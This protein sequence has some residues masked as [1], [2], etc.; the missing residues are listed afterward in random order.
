VFKGTQQVLHS[1]ATQRRKLNPLP[2]HS[3]AG[4]AAEDD[5]EVD[6]LDAFMAGIEATVAK[7]KTVPAKAAVPKPRRDDLE[8]ADD[9]GAQPPQSGSDPSLD[10]G[11]RC[12]KLIFACAVEK[13]IRQL[14]GPNRVRRPCISADTFFEEV[15]AKQVDEPDEIVEYDDD[16]YPIRK[17]K[18]SLMEVDFF[19]PSRYL[20]LSLLRSQRLP[21]CR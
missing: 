5:D 20:G 16:G 12:C 15:L 11:Y 3:S 21:Y 10:P 6:P 13:K 14:C 19:T 7:E 1:L 8:D 9:Q 17:G 18:E 4:A 2:C